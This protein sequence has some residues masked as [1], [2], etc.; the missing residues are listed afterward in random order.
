MASIRIYTVSTKSTG[1]EIFLLQTQK[2]LQ[3]I[4]QSFEYTHKDIK[5]YEI[6]P[7]TTWNSKTVTTQ[8]CAF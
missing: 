8:G 7:D 4:K 3:S 1:E 5:I 2:A 6:L